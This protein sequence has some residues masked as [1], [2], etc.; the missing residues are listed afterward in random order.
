MSGV[1]FA[2]V[3]IFRLRVARSACAVTVYARHRR[4]VGANAAAFLSEVRHL[5]DSVVAHDVRRV[6]RD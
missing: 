6:A 1:F 3:A 5:A 2:A 4:L